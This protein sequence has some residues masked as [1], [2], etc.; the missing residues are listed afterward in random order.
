MEHRN[1]IYFEHGLI[2]G[3]E[4]IG[5][6]NENYDNDEDD[7]NNENE[8]IK[9]NRNIHDLT[10]FVPKYK[11]IAIIWNNGNNENIK[12]NKNNRDH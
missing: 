10:I 8:K 4:W 7:D 5:N 2:I 1:E 3:E 11:R 9:E 6:E 12:D